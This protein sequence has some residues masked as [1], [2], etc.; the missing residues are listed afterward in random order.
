MG[1][2]GIWDQGPLLAL[3]VMA[4]TLPTMATDAEAV[5]EALQGFTL[6][7]VCLART[8]GVASFAVLSALAIIGRDVKITDAVAQ[9]DGC[10]EL[11][12]THRAG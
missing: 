3:V 11:K 10:L 4:R 9:C 5:T 2:L 8:A 6:C 1:S 12:N 7:T